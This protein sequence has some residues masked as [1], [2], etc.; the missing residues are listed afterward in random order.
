MKFNQREIIEISKIGANLKVPMKL[1]VDSINNSIDYDFIN[2]KTI[3][4]IL[5]KNEDGYEFYGSSSNGEDFN[6][7]AARFDILKHQI[8][9]WVKAIKRDN[10]YEAEKKA[11]IILLSENFYDIFQEATII[12]ALGFDDSSGMIYRKALEILVKDFL[13]VLLP[14]SFEDDITEKTI[15]AII[16]FFYEKKDDELKIR[17]KDRFSSMLGELEKIRHLTKIISNTFKIG[18]DFSHYERRLSEFT[19]ENMKTNILN[20]VE[21]IDCEIEEDILKFKKTML[22]KSFN[23]NKLIK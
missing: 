2:N 9:S 7:R 5:K 1:K 13:I 22:N 6:N 19:S 20:I 18:S 12:N 10:P 11:N 15:G 21:F 3:Q 23:L 14:E 4:S 17:E 16:H 8:T